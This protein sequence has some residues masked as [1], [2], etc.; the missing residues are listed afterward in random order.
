MNLLNDKE[1][2]VEALEVT[3][4]LPESWE[5]LWL[6]LTWDTPGLTMNVIGLFPTQEEAFECCQKSDT[7]SMFFGVVQMANVLDPF[8]GNS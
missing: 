8:L 2:L 1:G 7:G 3:T 5:R 4:T 6:A